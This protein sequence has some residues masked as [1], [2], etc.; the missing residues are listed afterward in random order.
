MKTHQTKS[1][2]TSMFSVRG[3][4]LDPKTG[5]GDH[6]RPRMLLDAPRVQLSPAQG[7]LEPL[8]FSVRSMFFA[9]AR[10]TY[11]LT[12]DTF[13]PLGRILISFEASSRLHP[14]FALFCLWR[15]GRGEWG[16]VTSAEATQNNTAVKGRGRVVSRYLS[17]N[18]ARILISTHEDRGDTLII[19][20]GERRAELFLLDDWISN[21]Q[22]RACG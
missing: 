14:Q 15:H 4:M 13:F 8:E 21:G 11:M 22:C 2:G 19:V 16:E 17:P 20:E 10:K 18:Q 6:T 7:S 9:T 3:W 1:I 5:V 12:G